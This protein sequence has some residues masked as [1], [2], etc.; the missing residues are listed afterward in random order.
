MASY[1]HMTWAQGRWCQVSLALDPRSR[2]EIPGATTWISCW[3][4]LVPSD[5]LVHLHHHEFDNCFGLPY[6]PYKTMDTMGLAVGSAGALV[7]QTALDVLM[8]HTHLQ[9]SKCPPPSYVLEH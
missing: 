3:G 5:G 8:A 2:I 9:L 7:G 1:M 6:G 4:L